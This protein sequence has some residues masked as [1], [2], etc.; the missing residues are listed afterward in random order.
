MCQVLPMVPAAE[1]HQVDQL[2]PVILPT[3]ITQPEKERGREVLGLA[4][5]L[6]RTKWEREFKLRDREAG[7]ALEAGHCR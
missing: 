7:G 1:G 5:G 6:I 3:G 4:L 2:E